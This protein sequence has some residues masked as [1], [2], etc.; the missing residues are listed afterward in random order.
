MNW[1]SLADKVFDRL[2]W[3]IL[4]AVGWAI[5]LAINAAVPWW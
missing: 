3:G 5:G 1:Q 2:L 4:V